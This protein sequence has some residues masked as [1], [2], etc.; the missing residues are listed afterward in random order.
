MK[1]TGPVLYL[2]CLVPLPIKNELNESVDS[3]T[4]VTMEHTSVVYFLHSL[5][6]HIHFRYG[7]FAAE[8]F[9]LRL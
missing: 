2:F 6:V 3:M 4:F 5:N 9:N 1:H 7:F 8:S